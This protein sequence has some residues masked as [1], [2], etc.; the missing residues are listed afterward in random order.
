MLDLTY[1]FMI[2]VSNKE[3]LNI[4]NQFGS[5]S[6]GNKEN[7]DNQ[8]PYGLEGKIFTEDDDIEVEDL[9]QSKTILFL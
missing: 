4:F 9:S 1:H 8:T 5:I 2:K 3:I 6:H 7:L